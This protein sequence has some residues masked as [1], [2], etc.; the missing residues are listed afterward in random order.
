M[1]NLTISMGKKGKVSLKQ[2]S[3]FFAWKKGKAQ[4]KLSN[5]RVLDSL[6]LF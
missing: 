6:F 3:A 1:R 4:E 5:A 2:F